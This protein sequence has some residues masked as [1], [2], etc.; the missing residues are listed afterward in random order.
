MRAQKLET[1][2]RY[3]TSIGT[4]LLLL[5]CGGCCGQLPEDL[6]A[7]MG[8]LDCKSDMKVKHCAINKIRDAHGAPGLLQALHSENACIR[9]EAAHGLMSFKDSAVRTALTDAGRDRDPHVRMWAAY[10]LGEVGDD[11]ALLVLAE[12]EKDPKDF[13]AVTATEA[14]RKIR[15]RSPSVTQ[16]GSRTQ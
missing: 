4:L 7:L 3:G 5:V 1:L 8:L 11:G 15:E 2:K 10:S 13:V 16:E 6:P 12:L 14:A 9:A